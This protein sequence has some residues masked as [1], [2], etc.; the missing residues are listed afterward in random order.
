MAAVLWFRRD[1]RLGDHP[2]LL[3]A[4]DAAARDDPHHVVGLFVFDETLRRP[5]GS[6]RIAFLYRCLRALNEQLDGKLVIRRGDPANVVPAVAAEV[7]AATVHVSAD[8]GPYG[9][10]RDRAVER[11]LG[12]A[13]RQ[14][15]RTGS[16]Y[17]VAPGRIVRSDGSPYRVFTPFARAWRAHGWRSPALAPSEVRWLPLDGVAI[18]KDPAIGSKLL[19]PAGE[20]AAG[21]RLNAF[22]S[23]VTEYGTNRN[24]PARPATSRLS[25]YL[26]YGCIHPRT[27]LA[28]VAEVS[29]QASEERAGTADPSNGVSSFVNELAW[30]DFYADVL[31]HQPESA[32]EDLS[33]ALGELEYDDLAEVPVAER[34]AAWK[35]GRTGYPIVDAGMRQLLAEGWMHNRVRMITA[36][37][38]VKDLHIWWPHGA[39]WFLDQLVDGDLASNNAGWQWV[40]GTGTDAAPYFRVF[41][42]LLQGEKFDPQGEYVRRY[43]PELAGADLPGKSIHAPWDAP[44][45]LPEDYPARIVDH[46]AE[47]KET[48]R[49]YEA[50][51]RAASR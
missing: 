41:N 1:L 50:A 31:W 27:L 35:A 22:L 40:A 39:R 16:P 29:A 30:R 36:S 34:F 23:Q 15:V 3:A 51:R 18:P 10:A 49:R 28:K 21:D 38:L 37:F 32:R 17:A 47:R 24:L 14:L 8:F 2:A 25:P 43:V 44:G 20:A 6:A 5:A 19:P 42:P 48:L 9:A 46:A 12:A 7:D 4:R 26:K 45:G 13:G 33:P 11:A